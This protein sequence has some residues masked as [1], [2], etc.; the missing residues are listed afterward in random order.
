MPALTRL[1][2]LRW[3]PLQG[4]NV[5]PC[6]PVSEKEMILR[7]SDLGMNSSFKKGEKP[8]KNVLRPL[9]SDNT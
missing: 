2:D 6:N 9:T 7:E 4:E 8:T 1:K 3:Y 5:R